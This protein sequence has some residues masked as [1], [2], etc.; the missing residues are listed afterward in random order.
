M[1]NDGVGVREV[2]RMLG[3][4]SA[5]GFDVLLEG[6]CVADPLAACSTCSD[7]CGWCGAVWEL[8]ES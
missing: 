4:V 2:G 6:C 8:S 5:P 3:V 7:G 1:D